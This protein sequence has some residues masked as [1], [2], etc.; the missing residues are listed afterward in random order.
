MCGIAGTIGLPLASALPA[1]EQTLRALRHRGPDDAATQMI[2]AATADSPPVIFVHTR[3]AIIDLSPTGRQPM[4]L[5]GVPHAPWVTFN[6][7]IYNFQEL[8][9][10]LE[11]RGHRRF[12]HSDTE[13]LLRACWEWGE[14]ALERLGGMFAFAYADPRRGE[15]WLVRDRLG[16]K[17]LYWCRTRPGGV[18]FASE[19]RALIAAAQGLFEVRGNPAAIESFLAQGAVFTS[20]THIR[21]VFEV[22][23]GEV[24]IFDW[25]GRERRRRHYWQIPFRR[26]DGPPPE[27]ESLVRQLRERLHV[28]VEQHLCADVPVGVFLS[29]GMDSA[30]V[31]AV[32]TAASRLP[33]RTITIGFDQPDFDESQ[34]AARHA[35]LLGTQ[36]QTIRLSVNAVRDAF[37]DV[38]AAMD[39]PSVDGFNTYHVSRAARESG[40]KVVLSGLGGDEL[41]GG[42]ATFRDV[43]R[44]WRWRRW[45]GLLRPLEQWLRPLSR[46]CGSRW[47]L[48]TAELVGRKHDFRQIYMLRR[49]LFLPPERR[50]LHPLPQATDPLT[51][52]PPDAFSLP[53]DLDPENAVSYLE[54]KGYMRYML[55]RDADVSSMA[56][57]LELRV[58]L[59]DHRVVET[60]V[61]A[62]GRW[63]R[64]G[65]RP[66]RL[67][68][69]A[70]GHRLPADAAKGPKRGFTFP[71]AAWLRRALAPWAEERLHARSVWQR[72]GFDP[73]APL[74]LWRRFLLKDPAVGGLQMLALL[75][76]AE[77]AVRQRISV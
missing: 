54:I 63:K 42:Y 10:E 4:T 33:L 1:A 66:K 44:A 52:V 56:H 5:P 37:E 24:R 41:F 20:E 62:P 8:A 27:R 72:L 40:L 57:G 9:K 74:E 7:E 73:D 22:E 13:V 61:Q 71:W 46:L 11:S 77:L 70:V 3:L 21:D 17:P 64:P 31:A 67:L 18:L 65:R 38:L 23:P 35:Q 76:L 47:L 32:A 36:H 6:G 55:L 15:V 75:V 68:A 58:P 53:A 12:G 2:P 14:S 34:Q 19:V 60:V 26:R 48:K 49:E 69:E 30:A 45:L 16:I 25:S 43:P 28:A 59:L 51:G 39:Q 50:R 29:S